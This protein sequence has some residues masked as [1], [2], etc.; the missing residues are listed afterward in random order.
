MPLHSLKLLAC[1][2]AFLPVCLTARPAPPG[3]LVDLLM[4]TVADG[5]TYPTLPFGFI[6]VAPSSLT[7]WS[8]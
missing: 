1:V 7:S 2:A 6:K 8:Q 5:S 3:N 4:A